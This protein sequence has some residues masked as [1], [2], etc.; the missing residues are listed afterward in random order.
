MKNIENIT[1]IENNTR[2][3]K[4]FKEK[5]RE[6]RQRLK[7]GKHSQKPKIFLKKQ[8]NEEKPRAIPKQGQWR[9]EKP[10]AAL[11]TAP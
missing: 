1:F 11:K 4:T 7:R 3:K 2:T 8:V 10:D 9:K 5:K 6:K